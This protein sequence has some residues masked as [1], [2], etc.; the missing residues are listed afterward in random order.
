[1]QR[2][3]IIEVDVVCPE[4]GNVNRAARRACRNCGRTGFVKKS[5]PASGVGSPVHEH[6]GPV[7]DGASFSQSPG[8][9]P[10][11]ADRPEK[12]EAMDAHPGW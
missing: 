2:D 7:S 10:P 6:V 3:E 9:P 1:M 8:T 12:R 11:P 4:C 5:V